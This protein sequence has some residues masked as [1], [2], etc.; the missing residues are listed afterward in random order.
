MNCQLCLTEKPLLKKSH[1]V[2][3]FMYKSM[4]NGNK[5]L[6][7]IN[8]ND[9]GGKFK[10]MKTGYTEA[11]LLCPDCD[12]G[13]LGRLE[14]YVSLHVYSDSQSDSVTRQ[15]HPAEGEA[16]ECIRFENLDYTNT[17]LFFLSIL[18]RCH[19]STLE[20]FSQVNLGPHAERIRKMIFENNAGNDNEYEV[21]LI[22]LDTEG[23]R[24]SKSVVDPRK[25]S[26]DGNTCYVFH[27]NE[28]MYHFN[29]NEHNKMD[30]FTKGAIRKDNIMDI[31]KLKGKWARM[32]FDTYMGRKLLM[33]SNIQH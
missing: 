6:V 2:P 13:I 1:I 24:P 9:I 22:Q 19:I 11:N 27:I 25:I 31:V 15:I 16:L 3:N 29:V 33:K 32:H 20:V 10:Y 8:S 14:R 30:L 21:I 17:K 12:N 7:S 4:F 26:S 28:I 18:W 23:A 5:R